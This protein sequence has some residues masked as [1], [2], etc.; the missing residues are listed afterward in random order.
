MLARH[1]TGLFSK[2][3]QQLIKSCIGQ[4]YMFSDDC[5]ASSMKTERSCSPNWCR[6]RRRLRRRQGCCR[7]RIL[8]E[9][10]EPE[11]EIGKRATTGIMGCLRAGRGT[12]AHNPNAD[13]RRALDSPRVNASGYSRAVL[14]RIC[15]PGRSRRY[16]LQGGTARARSLKSLPRGRKH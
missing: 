12:V 10:S 3:F 2:V 13:Q 6:Q 1:A 15:L 7:P 9:P 4:G 16:P 5:L 11:L 14:Q 8:Y